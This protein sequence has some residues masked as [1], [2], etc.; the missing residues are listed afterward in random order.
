MKTFIMMLIGFVL[1]WVFAHSTVSSECQK[2]GSFYVGNNVFD[3][4][5]TKK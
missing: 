4:S 1:G 5:L 3:C 2:V